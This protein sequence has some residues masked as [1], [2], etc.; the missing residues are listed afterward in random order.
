MISKEDAKAI[1]DELEKRMEQYR[2]DD[3]YGG[4]S[5]EAASMD[6]KFDAYSDA[7]AI[8]RRHTAK[9]EATTP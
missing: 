7:H 4:S 6:A 1:C 3:N 2:I 8:V 9:D 5:D